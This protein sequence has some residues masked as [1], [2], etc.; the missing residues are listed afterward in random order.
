MS[1]KEFLLLP[2]NIK[3]YWK[4]SGW[5]IALLV[6]YLTYQATDGVEWAV[7]VLP[8]AKILAEMLTR[9]LNKENAYGGAFN[10]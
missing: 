10:K 6:S 8:I 9:Y 1:I 2:E 7:T 4:A 3:A 5:A